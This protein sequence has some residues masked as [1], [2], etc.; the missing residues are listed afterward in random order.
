[1][2]LIGL[3]QWLHK[4]LNYCILSF[5]LYEFVFFILFSQSSYIICII[6]ALCIQFQIEPSFQFQYYDFDTTVYCF[7]RTLDILSLKLGR[8]F[9]IYGLRH[10]C[11]LGDIQR[12]LKIRITIVFDMLSSTSNFIRKYFL[13]NTYSKSSFIG[14]QISPATSSV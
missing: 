10:V 13:Y 5:V 1:M 6:K 14:D 9:Q 3:L 12:T 2:Q 8:F 7:T 4:F 11:D